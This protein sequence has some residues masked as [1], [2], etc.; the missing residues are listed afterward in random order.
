[1]TPICQRLAVLLL[2]CTAAC[3]TDVPTAGR[4][5]WGRDEG[6]LTPSMAGVVR[7]EVEFAGP[8]AEATSASRAVRWQ[9]ALRTDRP[10]GID[11]ARIPAILAD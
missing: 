2:L 4:D 7:G 11:P 6:E 3:Q 10:P 5:V 9:A 8:A 1:M